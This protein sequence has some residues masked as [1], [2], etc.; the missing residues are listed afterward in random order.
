MRKII[1]VL[2]LLGFY[3]ISA[4]SF[5][6]D[7]DLL[8]DDFNDLSLWDDVSIGSG[9]SE[10]NPAGQLHLDSLVV[11]DANAGIIRH[12]VPGGISDDYV[13]EARVFLHTI[14]T[15][16]G[17]SY[18]IQVGNGISRVWI[19]LRS[20]GLFIL[21]KNA[22]YHEVGSDI[23]QTGQWQVWRFVVSTDIVDVG[24][25]DV[26]LN[27]L[28]IQSNVQSGVLESPTRDG[29]T[30]LGQSSYN[31]HTESHTD[32]FRMGTQIPEHITISGFVTDS[33]YIPIQGARVKL[34]QKGVLIDETTTDVNGYY[35]F[36]G[37]AD[38][39]YV[40][41]G[42][43]SGF[44]KDRKIGKVIQSKPWAKEEYINLVLE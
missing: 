32:Y 7:W 34:K 30:Y 11:A 6:E 44:T 12:W 21:D 22:V 20:N 43:K 14:G 26:Y 4:S 37:L 27:G 31:I 36:K 40:V 28:L 10:I 2:I 15:G 17:N 25:C 35:E 38:G 8:N 3:L 18:T 41:I 39:K 9:Y 42:N 13:I 19:Q 1:L 29:L 24:Y 33:V 5:A 23:V 16:T